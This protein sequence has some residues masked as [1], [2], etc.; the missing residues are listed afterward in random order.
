MTLLAAVHSEAGTFH[1]FAAAW[2]SI[3]RAVAP[4]L[5]TYSCEVRMP[6]LAPREKTTHH[7]RLGPPARGGRRIFGGDF[8]PVAFEFFSDELGEPGEGAL[9]HFRSRDANDDGVVGPD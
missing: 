6:R 9:S 4:P 8:R 7:R 1:S 3:M 2:T 5:R